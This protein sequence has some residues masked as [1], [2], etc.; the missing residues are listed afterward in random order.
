MGWLSRLAGFTEH[1]KV[2]VLMQLDIRSGQGVAALR[3]IVVRPHPSLSVEQCRVALVALL[4]ARTLVNNEE[5]RVELFDRMARA[6][7]RV[8]EGDGKLVFEPWRLHVFR[9]DFSIWPWAFTDPGQIAAAKTYT[10]TLQSMTR[11]SLAIH[12]KMALGQDRVLAPSS[13]LIAASGLATAL[14]DSDRARLA[15]VLLGINAHYQSPARIGLRSEPG[16]LAAAMPALGVREA[17]PD[18]TG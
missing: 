16:A 6:A 17:P 12:L 8:L 11:G 4:Y 3:W 7:E 2:D 9:R 1:L 13:A 15:R 14:S 18:P 10:A 5:T